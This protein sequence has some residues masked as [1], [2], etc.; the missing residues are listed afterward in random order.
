MTKEFISLVL[1]CFVGIQRPAAQSSVARIFFV[2]IG[3]GAATLIVSPAGRTLLVDGGPPGGGTTRII[4]LLNS[5]GISTIDYTVLTHYH[6]DHMAGIAE[7]LNAGRVVGIAYDNGDGPTVEPPGT[8]TSPTSTRGAYL[9]YRTATNRPGVTRQT[10]APGTVIDLGGGMTATAVAAAGRLLSG[11][12]IAITTADLNTESISL[13]VEYNAFD[14]L[15][16]GDLTGGGSTS[17][18]KTPD[19]ET[20]VGQMVGDVDVVQLDHHGSTTANNQRFLSALKAEVAVAQMG[21][22]NTFGHP[23][24]ETVNKYLNTTTSAGNHYT[25][26]GVPTPGVGPVFYQHEDSPDDDDR[27]SHQ[28]I[29]STDTP[30]NGTIVLETDGV[31]NYTLKSHDDGGGRI[32]PSLNTY[33]IDGASAGITADFAPTVVVSTQ[34]VAP[35]ATDATTISAEVNDRESAISSV[36]LQYA[37]NGVLQSPIAMTSAGAAYQATI[38]PQPDGTRVD[39]AVTANAGTQTT[40]Y[41]SGYFSGVVTIATIRTPAPNGEP[42]FAGYAAR[43]QGVVSAGSNTFGAGSNDDY[44]QDATAG[45]DVYRSNETATP[46]TFTSAGQNV[47]VIGRIGFNGG[48]VRLDIT[49]SLEKT[50][51]P[52]GITILPTPGTI[53]PQPATFASLAATA[54]AFEG[55]LVTV[56]RVSVVSGGFPITP[57]QF[58]TFLTVT[59]GRSNFTLKI[60]KDTDIEGFNPGPVF[61]MVGVVQQDDYL[62]PFDSGYNIAPRGRPDLGGSAAGATLITIAEAKA[63]LINNVDSTPGADFVPDLINQIVRIRGAVTSIDFRGGAGI[64]YY[65]QDATGGIDL[66]ST[67]ADVG[68]FSIG[69]SVEAVGSVAQFNGLTELVITTPAGVSALPPG[70][71]SPASPQVVTLSQFAAGGMG[72]ALEGRLIRIDNVTITLGVFP[73]SGASGN[74]TISDATGSATLRIDSDTNIDGAPTPNGILSIVGIATQFDSASPFD[75]GYQILPRSTSDIS[76]TVPALSANPTAVVFGSATIGTTVQ[77]QVTLTNNTAATLTLVTPFAVTGADAGQFSVGSP[78]STTLAGGESTTVN[79]NFAPTSAGMKSAT[80]VAT[81]ITGPSTSVLLSGNAL[82]SGLTT[83]LVISEF[84]TRGPSGGNDEFVE[85]YNTTDAPIAIG[86][87]LLRG[88]NATGTV[89]TRATIPAGTI[90]PG[91]GHYLFTN[92]AAGGYSGS[93]PGNQTYATGI[94]DDGGIAVTTSALAVLDS[95]GMSTGSTFKEGTPLLPQMTNVNLSYERKVGG[96]EGSQID[97][98]NNANDFFLQ[99]TSDPQNLSSP[100]TPGISVSPALIDFGSVAVGASVIASVTIT[101]DATNT[102]TLTPPF[103]VTGPGSAAF[104]VATPATPTLGQGESTTVL[105]TFQPTAVGPQNATVSLTSASG[106]RIVELNGMATAGLT[107]TPAAVDFGEVAVGATASV[108]ITITNSGTVALTLTPPF[109]I[110]GAAASQFSV[111]VPAAVS[112]GANESTTV[113]ASFHPIAAGDKSAAL[114]ITSTNGGTRTVTLVGSSSCPA[115]TIAGALPNG[116]MGVPYSQTLGASGGVAPYA[117]SVSSGAPPTGLALA[118]SGTLSGIPLVAGASNFTVSA[119]DANGC[120]GS[121]QYVVGIA[122]GIASLGADSTLNFGTV[123]AN[124]PVTQNLTVTN[125]SA[126]AVALTPPFSITGA[127]ASQFSAGAPVIT[128]LAAHASATIPVTFRGSFP[129]GKSATLQITSTFSGVAAVTLAAEAVPA[130]PSTVLISEF[131]F[132][133]PTGASD[134]FVELYNNSDAPVAIGGYVLRASNATGTTSARAT[135]PPNVTIPSRGHYLFTNVAYSGSVPGQPYATAITDDGGVGIFDSSVATAPLDQVGTSP[136]SAYREGTPLTPLTNTANSYE[137]LPGGVEGNGVDTDDNAADFHVAASNPQNLASPSTPAI[138]VSPQTLNFAAT[139][140]GQSTAQIITI[141]NLSVTLATLTPPFAITGANAADFSVGVPAEATLPV[142]GST[143]AS[144]AFHPLTIGAKTAHL[145]VT[146]ASGSRVVTLSGEAT[147]AT[148]TIIEDS[149]TREYGAA[150]PTFTGTLTGLIPCDNITATFF[151]PATLTSP[152]GVYPIEYVLNDPDGR[153]SNYIVNVVQGTLTIVDTTA[154]VLTFPSDISTPQMS[155]LGAIVT[156]TASALDLLDGPVPVTCTPQSGAFFSVGVTLVTCS[157]TDA[158]GNSASGL[159]TVT[160]TEVSNPG[161]IVGAG[162]IEDGSWEHR[163]EIQVTERNDVEDGKLRYR[164]RLAMR[165]RDHVHE[166]IATGITAVV[167][168][169]SNFVSFAGNGRWNGQSGYV[170]EAMAVDAGEPGKAR[171]RFAIVIRDSVGAVMSAT[172]A[173]LTHGNIQAPGVK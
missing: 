2:D 152:P 106:T 137:R 110:T 135:V 43:I 92:S 138:A 111:S 88:S 41:G 38:P 165:G 14:Y 76:A 161:K 127:D 45:I 63:D 134:E 23:N 96:V 64:E 119:A 149:F 67:T 70:T 31:T 159:L 30:G 52:Y 12:A 153:L 114:S 49:E 19:I 103:A 97:T 89:S 162:Q 126:F 82:S 98:D 29:S 130:P 156:F 108:P 79:V 112:V 55:Q 75:S 72:E 26:T 36:T 100:I 24:R 10:I 124:I 107:V 61:T 120:T 68:P 59:D 74:L 35:L 78:G 8:S 171:D 102:A 4:P 18:V 53:D 163:F 39:Y 94:T 167:F 57:Q 131:R 90:I 16:S 69:D 157:A 71:V 164:A 46:F 172:D 166:F 37:I 139:I 87:Y 158:R 155:A 54:E 142:G 109:A 77:R 56:T 21:E 148:L 7:L 95:V 47:E 32:D 33:A 146:S 140:A 28:G 13:L 141:T 99:T 15:V 17:T 5:L 173:L 22:T 80:L 104:S 6:I 48:R 116:T 85:L 143:T 144:V 58:D 20:Y 42:L 62:R 122:P 170:F 128:A 1:L 168:T 51:S 27:V 115:I 150:N 151:S 93:V 105:V 154:P 113:S 44:V 132:R 86:G 9:N 145:T 117:F 133:G 73:A 91:R 50:T 81:T 65:V 101:N 160:V 60:D 3:Q 136:G 169:S 66:F 84:R 123:T 129:G 83:P 118:T 125:S 11:G 25:D 34:P 121:S 40:T 147:A